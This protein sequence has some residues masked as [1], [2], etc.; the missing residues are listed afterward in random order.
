MIYRN[1]ADQIWNVPTV[2]FSGVSRG[3]VF[4]RNNMRNVPKTHIRDIFGFAGWNYS[5]E[6]G[7]DNLNNPG[8]RSN[9]YRS[10]SFLDPDFF[11]DDRK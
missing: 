2:A 8:N 5:F 7:Q 3:I 1:V 9:L 10:V 4:K 6:D 11:F